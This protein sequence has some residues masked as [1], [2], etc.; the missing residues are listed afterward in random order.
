M[1]ILGLIKGDHEVGLYSTSVKIYNMVNT[2]IASITWVVMPKL[3]YYFSR[4]DFKEINKLLKYALNFIVVLGIPSICG[5]EIIAPQLIETIAGKAYVDAALSLRLL[6][7]A[8]LCSFFGGWIGNMTRLPAGQEAISLRITTIS[9]LI[10]ISLNL[11][12]IPRWGLNAA[13]FTTAVSELFGLIGG[14]ILLDRSIKID[15]LE[16]V[17]AGPIIG[18]M[19]ILAIGYIVKKTVAKAWAISIVTIVVSVI[20]YLV[21]MIISKNEFFM[22]FIN[23]IVRK[24]RGIKI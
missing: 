6:G 21:V 12:L 8:M 5:L 24:M 1:T 23:P 22:G 3:S 2:T 20:W 4:R 18:G 15:G 14:F 19:G 17:F 11:F 13:A 10:N 16:Q 7:F 9:A